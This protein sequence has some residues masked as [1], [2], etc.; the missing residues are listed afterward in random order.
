MDVDDIDKLLSTS[1]LPT[2]HHSEGTFPYFLTRARQ[3]KGWTLT[4]AAAACGVSTPSWSNWERGVFGPKLET[5]VR[6]ADVFGWPDVRLAELA[7]LCAA[8]PWKGQAE[9]RKTKRQDGAPRKSLKR[10]YQPA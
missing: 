10:R 6:M 4:E 1:L 5:V 8:F 7:R 3:A 2:P 9:Y